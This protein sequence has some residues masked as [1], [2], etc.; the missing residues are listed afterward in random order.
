[1]KYVYFDNAA[2]SWPKPPGVWQ[3]M[4][5]FMHQVGASPGRAGH[6]RTV[7]AN[8]IV[9]ETR[10]LLARQFNIGNPEQIIFTLNA[11]DALNIALKGL[12][13]SGDHVVTSSMEHNSVSRPLYF[14]E[15]QGVQVT[16]VKCNHQGHL[17]VKETEAA[18]RPNTKLLVVT[19]AS[20][21]TGTLMPVKELGQLAKKYNLYFLLDAS[22]TAGIEDIDVKAFNIDVLAC[23][24][25]K[26]LFGPQGTG[27]LYVGGGVPMIPLRQG[28][29]GSKSETPDQPE[30]MP[31]KYESGTLNA[32]GIAGLGAGLKFIKKEGIKNIR[33]KEKQL[34]KRFLARAQQIPKIVIYGPLDMDKQVPVVSFTFINAKA[35]DIGKILDEKYNIACRAGLHCAPD[36]HHTIGTFKNK[37]IRFSFSYFN[38]PEEVD[39]ALMALKQIAY[40]IP[41]N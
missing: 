25:H 32:I 21:V 30:I 8:R 18:I 23:P 5:Y 3:A 9:D 2:T 35:G 15:Q 26:S 6:K 10:E 22:Q 38:T 14:L 41:Q 16:K 17:C 31:E 28:G 13:K 27:I 39:Y 19:H 29:T 1:M 20:N 33:Q 11:T 34:A 36:A 24:G 4:D 12:L 37:L 40:D 7:E